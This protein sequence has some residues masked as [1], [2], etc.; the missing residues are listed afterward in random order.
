MTSTSKLSRVQ[1]LR[2]V[3]AILVTFG[4]AQAEAQQL[5]PTFYRIDFA[6]G[7][8]VD[9]FFVISGFIMV[10]SS[11]SL[12]G[13][14]GG[15]TKFLW[16]RMKRV[17]PLYWIFTLL[18]VLAIFLAPSQLNSSDFELRHLFLSLLFIP[19]EA[20]DG[21]TQPI[22]ALGWTL[23]YEMFF[24]AIFATVLFFS[25]VIGRFALVAIMSALVL[26]G[27]ILPNTAPTPIIFWSNPILLEFLFGVLAGS[28]YLRHGRKESLPLFLSTI[29]LSAT[30]YLFLIDLTDYRLFILGAP[31]ILFSIAFIFFMPTRIETSFLT[32]SH[33]AGDS[34]Y[35]LYLSHPFT[36]A[37]TKL[38]WVKL[39]FQQD[40]LWTFV[41]VSTLA[42]IAVGYLVYILIEGPISIALSSRKQNSTS[43]SVT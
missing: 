1:L 28:Y 37:L 39:G 10:I 38:A 27:T 12:F 16:R 43:L 13:T 9:I 3:A 5:Y 31:A 2:G 34:S 18:M 30:I 25:F 4:H 23:N 21:D 7:I 26:M 32:V 35:S 20:A 40:H 29:I 8:G 11:Q 24:Y 17:V 6:F 36:L 22:L 33:L 42:S 14:K 19:Y 15:F 41:V